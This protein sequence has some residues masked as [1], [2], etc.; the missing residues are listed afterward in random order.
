MK[1]LRKK[2]FWRALIPSL[3]F[4]FKNLPFNQAKKLP[5]WVHKMHCLSQKGRI[6]IESDNIY[7]GMIQLGFPRAAT[8]RDTG[9]TWRNKGLIIFKGSCKIGNDCHVIVGKQGILTFGE[10]FKANA[11]VKIVS[12]CKITFGSHTRFGW[13]CIMMDTNF[14]PLYDME[15]KK[16]KRAFSPILIGDYNWFGLQCYIMHGVQTPERCIFG[17]RSVVTRGGQYESY[18][19][20][21]GS[22]IRVLSRNVMRDYE[23]DFVT[24]YSLPERNDKKQSL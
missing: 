22:P 16:F 7:T 24:D 3:I 10:D 18:C 9:I 21:G 14:H 15:K 6:I 17:A 13:G 8:Y 12:E 20:H 11:G 1:Y 19:V 2:N 5:I 23:H 4:N